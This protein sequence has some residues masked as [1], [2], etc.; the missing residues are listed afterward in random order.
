MEF[1]ICDNSCP[2]TCFPK[3]LD[4]SEFIDITT[5]SDVWGRFLNP[6]TGDIHNCADY[7]QAA[8]EIK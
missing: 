6:A 7:Y 4:T 1:V 5:I 8:M 2:K 3:E